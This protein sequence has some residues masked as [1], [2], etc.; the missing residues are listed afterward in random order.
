[1]KRLRCLPAGLAGIAAITA[2]VA[3][4]LAHAGSSCHEVS[5]IVGYEQCTRFGASWANERRPPFTLAFGVRTFMFSPLGHTFSAK[6]TKNGPEVYSFEGDILGTKPLIASGFG[7]QITGYAWR[8]VYLGVESS[9]AFGKNGGY[10][11]QA[12]GYDVEPSGWLDTFAFAG[13][14]LMGARIPLGKLSLRPEMLVGGRV[15]SLSQQATLAGEA[16]KATATTAAWALEPRLALDMWVLPWMTVSAFAGKD[17]RDPRS[18]SF[19]LM[20]VGHVRAYDG[21]FSL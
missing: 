7:W 20:I 8:N 16:K 19:G 13:G 2:L 11:F 15:L 1:M 3:P 6:T 14:L 18:L 5:D 17:L 9:W 21:A 10:A 4:A 12:N